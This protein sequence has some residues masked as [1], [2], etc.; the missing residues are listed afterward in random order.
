MV[1]KIS[2]KTLSAVFL[3]LSLALFL[4]ACMSPV[5]IGS[6]GSGG[7]FDDDDVKELID[8]T[9]GKVKIDPESDD[10]QFL[11]PENRRISGLAPNRY[12]MV[13]EYNPEKDETN[14][15]FIQNTGNTWGDL[16]RID[17]L[18]GN[19]IIGLQNG[20]TYK[21]KYARTFAGEKDHI[22]F[23]FGDEKYK[24]ADLSTGNVTIKGTKDYYL[25]VGTLIDANK[26]YQVMKIPIP[27]L[28]GT[29]TPWGNSKTSANYDQ[30]SSVFDLGGKYNPHDSSREIGIYQYRK[31]VYADPPPK[32]LNINLLNKS[33]IAL[34]GINT[35]SDYVFAEYDNSGKITNFIVLNINRLDETIVDIK[36]DVTYTS[37]KSPEVTVTAPSST[38][39]SPDNKYSFSQNVNQDIIINVSNSTTINYTKIEWYKDNTPPATGTS[40]TFSIS[41]ANGAYNKQAG[42]HQ[43][44]VVGYKD[45]I[46]Y[47]TIISITITTP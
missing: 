46:P 1:E 13:E 4:C 24:T 15:Y 34:T 43:I 22:Y 16:S 23:A 21:V 5:N 12:Y 6:D 35:Q 33:L 40:Y 20:C 10:S 29:N 41:D 25:N 11:I 32:K 9:K 38:Q 30:N 47:S 19:Q 37:E 7:F 31:Q 2:K 44:M 27:G 18:K 36:V 45:G 42:V 17:R 14:N 26:V 39:I 28:S 8:W 3:M